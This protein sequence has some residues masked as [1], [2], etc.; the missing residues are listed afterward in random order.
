[1]PCAMPCF[2]KKEIWLSSPK[3]RQKSAKI[4]LN[5]EFYNMDRKGFMSL[6][7]EEVNE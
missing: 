5:N 7:K 4:Q 2:R 1:M 6:L 3:L